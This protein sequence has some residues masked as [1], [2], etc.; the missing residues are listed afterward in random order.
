VAVASADR[1]SAVNTRRAHA[2]MLVFAF[3]IS[4]SFT[5]GQAITTSLDPVALTF[6]RFVLAGL[7]FLVILLARGRKLSRPSLYDIG[8]YGWLALLLVLYF[9][10][11]FEALRWTDALSTGVIFTLAP[12]MT[13]LMSWL[14][15]GQR[16]STREALA[17]GIAG[18]AAMWVM[19]DGSYE[20]LM[21]F[22]LGKGEIIFLI[23]AVCYAAYSP[24]VRKLHRSQNLVDLTM[25]TL[26]AGLIL[27]AVYGWQII[28]NVNWSALPAYV[29][30]GIA[31]LAIFTT[32]ISFYLIQYASLYLP[33][34]KVM[35]YTYLIPAFIVL[36][37]IALGAPLPPWPVLAG[38]IVIASAMI[39][40]QR[41]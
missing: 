33:S 27:L 31:H 5:V 15:L 14:V 29:Y 34:G 22:S 38:V 25:W 28:S 30:L 7:I 2:A 23:G 1:A 4:S 32:A 3:L 12:P 39:I 9:V 37:N 26:I 13:V 21:S 8:R 10:L 40:L 36:Q 17:L 11:M 18:L 19:F 41:S 6:M 20:K 24:S 16:F 35:A